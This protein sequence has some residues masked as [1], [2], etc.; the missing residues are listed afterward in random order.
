MKN[1]IKFLTILSMVFTMVSCNNDDDNNQPDPNVVYEATLS[2]ANEV[3]SNSSTATGAAILTLN[4]D[5]KTFVVKVTHDIANPSMGH[6]HKA[7]VGENGPVIFPFTSLASPISYTSPVLTDEQIADLN[8]GLLYVN[9]HSE[10]LPGGEI[11]GN[12][13][14]K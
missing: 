6:I 14:K 3:P 11:R 1:T 13:V 4:K 10:A 2:G 8:N 12:L 9:I 5:T 7:A